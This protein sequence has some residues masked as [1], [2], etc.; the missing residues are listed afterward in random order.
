MLLES[1]F[2]DRF[3]IGPRG[4]PWPNRWMITGN[5]DI[6]ILKKA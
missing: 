6:F 4:F 2:I 5:A 1:I 3:E